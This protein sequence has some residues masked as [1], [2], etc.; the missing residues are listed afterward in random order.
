MAVTYQVYEWMNM[1]REVNATPESLSPGTEYDIFTGSVGN[2]IS[3]SNVVRPNQFVVMDNM[4]ITPFG[5]ASVNLRINTTKY[6][7]NPDIT[8]SEGISGLM[9]PY[10]CGNPSDKYT[11]LTDSVRPSFTLE[12]IP[13]YILPGQTRSH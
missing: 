4:S 12:K 13:V 11:N 3:N 8:V 5:G 10:P 6:F 2:S 1:K 9:S 7:Q